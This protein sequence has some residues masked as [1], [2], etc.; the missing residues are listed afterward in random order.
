MYRQPE[1]CKA[2]DDSGSLVLRGREEKLLHAAIKCAIME[3][4]RKN[5]YEHR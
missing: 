3:S 4:W 2:G 5:N 1:V